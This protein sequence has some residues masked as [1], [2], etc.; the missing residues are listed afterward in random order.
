[1]RTVQL[2]FEEFLESRRL[3]NRAVQKSVDD[4]IFLTW[5]WLSTWWKHF[6]DKRRFLVIAVIDGNEIAAAAPFMTSKHSLLGLKLTKLQFIGSPESDYHGFLLTNGKEQLATTMIEYA[7]RVALDWDLIELNDIPETFQTARILGKPLTTPWKL[8]QDVEGQCPYIP[9]P[10]TFE[11]YLDTLSL[12]F[13]KNLKTRERALTRDYDI[14]FRVLEDFD[15]IDGPM[16]I[17]FELHEKRRGTKG[18]AGIFAYPTVRN[19]HFDV[20]KSFAQK[21]WLV[22]ALLMLNGEP[23]AAQYAFKY[24]NKLYCYQS[25]FDPQYSKY[26]VGSLLEMYLIRRSIRNRLREYDFTRGDLPYKRQWSTLART[27]LQ[28]T[29]TRRKL[30]RLLAR[31]LELAELAARADWSERKDWFFSYLKRLRVIL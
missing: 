14:D 15:S 25:G 9:L 13:R 4:N 7:H 1:M 5:E 3:W 6:G 19:F 10:S 21:G 17:L 29:A 16:R 30:V 11:D 20:A 2:T 18:E 31:S 24:A 26:G 23:A 12:H 27:N 22:L 28:F 8:E